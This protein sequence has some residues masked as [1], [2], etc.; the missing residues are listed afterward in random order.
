MRFRFPDPDDDGEDIAGDEVFWRVNFLFGCI[1]HIIYINENRKKEHSDN[2]HKLE[3]KKIYFT[4]DG[5]TPFTR[6]L[7]SRDVAQT[8]L[9]KPCFLKTGQD[10]KTYHMYLCS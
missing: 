3:E 5:T 2:S 1:V 4:Y 6:I 9:S 10:N 8:L 7:L